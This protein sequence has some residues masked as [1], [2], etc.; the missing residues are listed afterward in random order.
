[1]KCTKNII[2]KTIGQ[3]L[4]LNLITGYKSVPVFM[5]HR[6]LDN[7]HVGTVLDRSL[8]IRVDNFITV[9]NCIKDQFQVTSLRDFTDGEVEP[10]V[11][12]CILTFDDGWRDNYDVAFP[13]LK[14]F[15]LPA[16]IF[17]TT[18]MVGTADKFWFSRLEDLF[19]VNCDSALP[20]LHN[21]FPGLPINAPSDFL[22]HQLCDRFKILELPKINHILDN[23]ES[24]V[25]FPKENI[26]SVM[27]WEEM[28]EMSKS[29]ITFGSHG[30]THS[31]F[32][33]LSNHDKLMQLTESKK[34][35][36]NCA[37]FVNCFSFPNGNYDQES[38]DLANVAGYKLVFSASINT[39][40]VGTSSSLV[41]RICVSDLNCDKAM[42]CSSLLKAKIKQRLFKPYRSCN[43]YGPL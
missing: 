42:L 30:V 12:R 17:V 29:S 22:F 18:S 32:P 27:S 35:L 31:I 19:V 5:F 33:L 37:G 16:T 11:K 26:R 7:Y 9:L 8:Y 3:L 24:V 38:L 40:G 1:M 39:C 25:G 2:K 41:H 36:T 34:H 4:K 10:S 23:L 6:V 14:Q 20:F 21:L 43:S 13:I 28:E 15:G